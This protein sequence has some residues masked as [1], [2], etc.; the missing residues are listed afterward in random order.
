MNCSSC[1]NK[2]CRTGN[3]CFGIKDESLS[4]LTSVRFHNTA[5]AASS[6]IDNGKA[7]S[8]NRLEEIIEYCR[9]MKY[10]SIGI[11]YCFGVAGLAKSFEK[12]LNNAGLSTLMIQCTAGGVKEKEIDTTKTIETVSCNPA[13]QALFLKKHNADFIVEMGLCLGHDVIFHTLTD[14]PFT[15]FLVKDRV[16]RHNPAL[17]L[18]SYSDFNSAFLNDMDPQFRMKTPEW[19]KERLASTAPLFIVDL[20]STE[21]FNTAHIDGSI[22]A[23][24]SS[25]PKEY[26]S[27]LPDSKATVVAVCSGSVQSAYAIMFLY[28]RGYRDVFNLSGGFSRWEKEGHPVVR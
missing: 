8:L 6:L 11:A 12:E 1:K 3:D 23:P 25:L 24:L 21:A 27:L 10:T 14:I 9:E 13:G 19:L 20:R 22:N 4:L 2:S 17:A 26:A 5:S 28:S 7:G 15:V 18:P 16:L